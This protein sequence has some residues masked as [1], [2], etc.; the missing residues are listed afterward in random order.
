MCNTVS[1]TLLCSWLC[2]FGNHT[3]IAHYFEVGDD[4]DD[5]IPV[6]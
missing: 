4:D 5:N 6:R 2:L 1:V 3:W